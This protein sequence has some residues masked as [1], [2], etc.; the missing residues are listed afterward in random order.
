MPGSTLREG[1]TQSWVDK[2]RYTMNAAERFLENFLGNANAGLEKGP[3]ESEIK[4]LLQS[5]LR[6]LGEK[7][8][9]SFPSV[10]AK[11]Q[12][13]AIEYS[14]ESGP[15]S[16]YTPENRANLS[17]LC[18]RSC[19]MAPVPLLT[20]QHDRHGIPLP[21]RSKDKYNLNE[22][23][24]RKTT[25]NSGSQLTTSPLDLQEADGMSHFPSHDLPNNRPSAPSPIY[26]EEQCNAYPHARQNNTRRHEEYHP[27]RPDERY[28]GSRDGG[29]EYQ[30]IHLFRKPPV[31]YPILPIPL[32]F[33]VT[34]Y[35][36]TCYKIDYRKPVILRDLLPP[37]LFPPTRSPHY[38]SPRLPATGTDSRHR[39]KSPAPV[40][41]RSPKDNV[42]SRISISAPPPQNYGTVEDRRRLGD[43]NDD[44]GYYELRDS[45]R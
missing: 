24:P 43:G 35:C 3:K 11:Y 38:L 42:M 23:G 37:P 12:D 22:F 45:Q 20:D 5:P 1:P 7:D 14:S 15:K 27:L 40:V 29:S 31:V 8:E 13:R 10:C 25:H 26:F 34:G 9:P 6:T 16:G 36:N 32:V 33:L 44:R 17:K 2:D 28:W 4:E 41:R 19:R 18:E 39:S 30:G 21:Q